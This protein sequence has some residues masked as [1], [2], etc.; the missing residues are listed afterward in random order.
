M[1]IKANCSH[2]NCNYHKHDL[3]ENIGCNHF[4]CMPKIT[5][6]INNRQHT[7]F[8]CQCCL[9]KNNQLDHKDKSID[10]HN[11]TPTTEKL[12]IINTKVNNFVNHSSE[13]MFCCDQCHEWFIPLWS[14]IHCPTN[15]R[16]IPKDDNLPYD[17]QNHQHHRSSSQPQTKSEKLI[18]N[19]SSSEIIQYDENEGRKVIKQTY[20]LG[21]NDDNNNNPSKTHCTYE[22]AVNQ[23]HI[24]TRRSQ[25]SH[26][27]HQQQQQKC[28]TKR[29]AKSVLP[30]HSTSS[31]TNNGTNN[32]PM[33]LSHYKLHADIIQTEL[34]NHL[35]NRNDS[36]KKFIYPYP[37]EQLTNLKKYHKVRRQNRI[38]LGQLNVQEWLDK[39]VNGKC[40]PY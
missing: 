32:S 23:K 24:F 30:I 28:R 35:V 39:T 22:P 36:S 9:Y 12:F 13:R 40:S 11:S 1:F 25:Q 10:P 37:L 19:H 4:K 20:E 16:Y 7:I 15:R 31:D 6:T 38:Y 3:I 8:H 29:R 5:T 14:Q 21:N 17:H 18:Q 2:L 34:D 33:K 26:H 27:H